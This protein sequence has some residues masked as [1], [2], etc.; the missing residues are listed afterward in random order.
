M[1][2][3]PLRVLAAMAVLFAA[4][5]VWIVVSPTVVGYHPGGA[6]WNAATQND[7]IVGGLLV[8]VSLGLLIVQITATI[9]VRRRAVDR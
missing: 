1:R 5:G 6:R 7:V 9:R 3:I 4:V 8:A 2:P